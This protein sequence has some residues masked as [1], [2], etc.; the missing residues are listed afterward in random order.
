MWVFVVFRGCCRNED[1]HPKIRGLCASFSVDVKQKF[2]FK[3]RAPYI[4]NKLLFCCYQLLV[5]VLNLLLLCFWISD[6]T[7]GPL[8]PANKIAIFCCCESLFFPVVRIS[9]FSRATLEFD[10]FICIFRYF[11]FFL[12]FNYLENNS[13]WTSHS[14]T[15]NDC[16]TTSKHAN[17]WLSAI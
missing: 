7:I 5:L 13:H 6:K 11:F 12:I 8:I 1:R 10:V 14:L 17:K 16:Q 2:S 15:R 9:I 4:K 3:L